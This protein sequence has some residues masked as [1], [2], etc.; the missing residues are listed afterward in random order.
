[1]GR[2]ELSGVGHTRRRAGG[3][4]L[5]ALS[6]LSPACAGDSEELTELKDQVAALEEKLDQATTTVAPTT[7]ATT[8]STTSAPATTTST[9]TSTTTPQLEVQSLVE[10]TGIRGSRVLVPDSWVYDYSDG[11]GSGARSWWTN[12]LDQRE[13]VQISTGVSR[14]MWFEVDGVEGSITPQFPEG[15]VVEE[16]KPAAFVYTQLEGDAVR[17]GVWRATLSATR[18]HYCCFIHAW[19]LLR[20]PNQQVVAAFTEHQLSRVE[21]PTSTT[22]TQA[23]ATTTT[24]TQ[25]P[26]TTTTTTQAPVTTTSRPYVPNPS[27]LTV[28]DYND[29]INDSLAIYFALTDSSNEPV[30][31]SPDASLVVELHDAA[32]TSLYEG[33]WD[34]QSSDRR[35]WVT[36]AGVKETGFTIE[37]PFSEIPR[38]LTGSSGFIK[39]RL[40][41]VDGTYFDH[42]I[43]TTILPAASESE[44]DAA[45]LEGYLKGVVEMS[46]VHAATSAW[47]LAPTQAGCFTHYGTWGTPEHGVRVDFEIINRR[48]SIRS[49]YDDAL[50]IVPTGLTVEPDYSSPMTGLDVL[51][52]V[53]TD[54]YLF[55]KDLDCVAGTYRIV[56]SNYQEVFLDEAFTLDP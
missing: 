41:F 56:V 19:I 27:F 36:S 38:S 10:E 34:F 42:Y 16:V 31:K 2:D 29:S 51:P 9:T 30:A 24:T 49:W 6:L 12:P 1:M 7:S 26:A 48:E 17:A 44:K 55:F 22:T 20:E 21:T 11:G 47:Q 53:A 33:S 28:Q 50:L 25:A 40:T 3:A 4:C 43:S 13:Q 14:G 39:Y 54:S 45:A 23:P 32:W 35:E 46:G 8:T 18:D 15:S 52:N 5:V 37:I